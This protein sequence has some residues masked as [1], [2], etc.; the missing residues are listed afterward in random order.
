MIT[1]TKEGLPEVEK[2]ELKSI[3]PSDFIYE[4]KNL[5]QTYDVKLELTYKQKENGLPIDQLQ[6][7]VVIT[8][9][10]EGDKYY[11]VGVNYTNIYE[12]EA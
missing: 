11:V 12:K 1:Y 7:D 9:L 2:Y 6:K 10:E 8:L 5:N 3:S 4:A